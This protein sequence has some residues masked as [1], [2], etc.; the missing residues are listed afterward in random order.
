MIE[1]ELRHTVLSGLTAFQE[2]Q[3]QLIAVG[4]GAVASVSIGGSN[5][6]RP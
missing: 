6:V 3:G 4:T 2:T 1:G 5:C